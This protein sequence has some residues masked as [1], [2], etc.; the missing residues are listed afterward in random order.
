MT[1][2]LEQLRSDWEAA[3][4]AAEKIGDTRGATIYRALLLDVTQRAESA[5]DELLDL[6]AAARE[7]G[8]SRQ[9]IRK[10]IASGELP[11]AGRKG[12]PAVRRRDLP[13]KPGAKQRPAGSLNA[14]ADAA[15]LLGAGR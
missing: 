10:L 4:A 9:R 8:Y 1:P 13:R 15:R 5:G 3:A 12:A 2:W 11:N 7:S 14:A 6:E